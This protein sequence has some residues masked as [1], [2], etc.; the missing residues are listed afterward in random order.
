MF[1]RGFRPRLALLHPWQLQ[2]HGTT[3]G[4]R[5]IYS[6][7]SARIIGDSYGEKTGN[8]LW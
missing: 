6:L 7:R 5:Q 3:D 1:F 8:S 4:G 2:G